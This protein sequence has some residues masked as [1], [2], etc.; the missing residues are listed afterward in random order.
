[1]LHTPY[2]ICNTLPIGTSPLG[3][4]RERL[5]L[6]QPPRG[7]VARLHDRAMP[8]VVDADQ[9]LSRAA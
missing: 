7:V 2:P 1:M 8:V 5:R 6:E 9:P 3:L 4:A